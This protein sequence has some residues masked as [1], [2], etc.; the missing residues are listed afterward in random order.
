MNGKSDYMNFY[1]ENPEC[2]K[3]KL[4]WEEVNFDTKEY[5]SR[6]DNRYPTLCLNCH[7]NKKHEWDG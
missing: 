1:C 2:D 3:T 7:Y 5:A 4:S 6:G